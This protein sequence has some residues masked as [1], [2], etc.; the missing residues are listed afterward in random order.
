MRINEKIF[1]KTN[2]KTEMLSISSILRDML[3]KPKHPTRIAQLVG[4]NDSMA[5]DKI[6]CE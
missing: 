1:E 6:H 5:I 2:E 3:L 4:L